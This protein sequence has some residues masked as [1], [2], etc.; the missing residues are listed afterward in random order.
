VQHSGSVNPA[1]TLA[2]VSA[3]LASAS[4]ILAL[5]LSR[6]PGSGEQRWFAVI[7]FGSAAY[8]AGNLGTTLAAAPSL[9]VSLSRVQVASIFVSLWGWIRLSRTLDGVKPSR[10]ERRATW[11]LLAASPL[12][13][14]PGLVFVDRVFDRPY[15]PLDVVYRLPVASASGIALFAAFV[16]IAVAVE[17]RFVRAALRRASGAGVLATAFAV[18]VAMGVSDA[19]ATTQDLPLPFLL[20]SGFAVPLLAVSWIGASRFI[21]SATA[22]EKLGQDLWSQVEART[23]ELASAQ[24]NL[25]QAEKLAALGQFANGV[26]HEVNNPAAVVNSSLRFIAESAAAPGG[27]PLDP[28]SAAALADAVAAMERITSLVRKL[29]DA[30]RIALAP[31]RPAAAGVGAV[32][33]KVVDR[34]PAS[35]RAAIE[36]IGDPRDARAA[37]RPEALENVLETIVANAADALPEGRKGRI[38][39]RTELLDGSVRITVA[40]DGVGMPADV[41][42]RAFDPFFTTKPFGRGSGLGLPVARGLVESAGGALWLE[43]EPGAGTRAVIE[44]PEAPSGPDERD[45]GPAS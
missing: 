39:I 31:S 38:A 7:A 29:V 3:V 23:R 25:L 16:A 24:E 19:L 20:D 30:G 18:L 4:G 37:L 17:L 11:V 13:L 28:E 35:V 10:L 45:G 6:A 8:A 41:L 15:P 21:D 1:A 2:I 27:R 36:R 44:L 22:L 26:G 32:L 5:R 42:R 12:A 33:A 43:S 40:D 14:V 9:V 34:Q